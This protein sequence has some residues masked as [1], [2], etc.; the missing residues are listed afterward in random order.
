MPFAGA[1]APCTTILLLL[2][3]VPCAEG[4]PPEATPPRGMAIGQILSKNGCGA[5][6]GLV[7]ATAGVGQ[8]LREQSDAGLTVF[9]PDDGAVAAF[10]PRFSNLTADRQASLLLYHGLAVRSSEVELSLL[11]RLGGEI[12]VRTLDRGRWGYGMLTICDCG[13]TMRLSSSPPSFT[14]PDEARVTNTVVYNDR[15]TLYLIDAVLVPGAPAV[16]DYSDS[17]VTVCFLLGIVTLVLG[18]CVLSVIRA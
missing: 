4:Q 10:T 5:F 6:A 9:C 17:L 7:A 14:M 1:V 2:L 3:L 15:L 18:S 11:T 12:E 8:V 16:F 13:G